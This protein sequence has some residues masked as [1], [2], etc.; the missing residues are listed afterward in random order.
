MLTGLL[1]FFGW[2]SRPGMRQ[3]LKL[4]AEL[5]AELGELDGLLEVDQ[6]DDGT[7]SASARRAAGAVLVD[8]RALREVEVDDKVD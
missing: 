4:D 7:L 3:P 6:G 5:L 2:N 1:P 8:L